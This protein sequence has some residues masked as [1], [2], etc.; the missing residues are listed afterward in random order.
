MLRLL[1]VLKEVLSDAQAFLANFGSMHHL[2]VRLDQ[3][4]RA[5]AEEPPA[6]TLFAPLALREAVR[7]DNVAYRYPGA[8]GGALEAV[9]FEI[10]AGRITALV[11]P[12]GAGKSTVVELATALRRPSEGRVLFDR[13]DLAARPSSDVHRAVAYVPQEPG[14]LDMSVGEFLAL[15]RPDASREEIEEAAARAGADSFIRTLP[16]GYDAPLGENGDRLSGGQRQ[17]LD[18]ARAMVQ[19]AELLILDE[20]TSQLD[21]VSS[22]RLAASLRESC[23]TLGWTVLIV[24]HGA[25]LADQADHAVVLEGG[26]VADA[27]RPDELTRRAGWYATAFASQATGSSRG[28]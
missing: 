12:S 8:E 28:R 21:P 4:R 26:R 27:G 6:Q 15:G 10:P 16:G 25:D 24:S 20:P 23:E 11:G 2:T 7:F 14:V 5:S 19:G 1:P 22:R 18:L 9:S 17:R 13:E 3:L